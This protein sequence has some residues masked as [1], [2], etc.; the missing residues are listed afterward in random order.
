M[1][2]ADRVYSLGRGVCSIRGETK[3]DTRFI[4]YCLDWK[5]EALLKYAGGELFLTSLQDSIRE[6]EIPFPRHR[7]KI[8]G[9]LSAYDDLIENNLRR[10]KILE[11]MAQN[12]YREWFVKFRFPGHRHA[13]FTDSPGPDSGG[14]EV[15]RLGE[16]LELN[17]GKALKQEDR[18]GGDVPVYG[19]SGVVGHH[20]VPL[21][22][23][24]GIVVGRKGNVGSIFWSDEDFYPIDTAY[25]VT[26][27]MP[28]VFCSTISRRR[29]SST[30][31]LPC[32]A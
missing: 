7:R 32:R 15:Q 18:R 31:T 10:I 29:T 17:Y 24:P 2:W 8:A 14:W 25:F 9:I 16:V 22:N 1:N 21:V 26:S 13:R 20:D 5:L 4:K 19:S 27:K 3:I 12:L 23:G 30:T 6:F 28:Y 11:E